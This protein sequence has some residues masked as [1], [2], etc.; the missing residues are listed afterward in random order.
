M[1]NVLTRGLTGMMTGPQES[2]ISKLL[3]TQAVPG[4]SDEVTR[5][6]AKLVEGG[7]TKQ[8]ASDMIGWLKQLPRVELTAASPAG[9][10]VNVNSDPVTE[11]G[12]YVH[13][14][15]VYKV[16]RSKSSGR[17]YAKVLTTTI[18]EARRLTEAGETVNFDYVYAPGAF[19]VLTAANRLTP[20]V[21]ERLSIVY[22]W[23]IRCGRALKRA[24]SVA[25]GMGPVCR[26]KV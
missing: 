10:V 22:S 11:E 5:I 25:A 1:G 26:N 8:Q 3:D 12:L 6:R 4:G 18:P 21:A 17:L 13:D 24:E 23:C 19:R 16:Q 2:F 20:E 7:I 15:R 9:T 14:E